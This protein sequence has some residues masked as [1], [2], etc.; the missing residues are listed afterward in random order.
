MLGL[1]YVIHFFLA[2]GKTPISY[3]KQG[4][5]KIFTYMF[6][7]YTAAIIGI[8]QKTRLPFFIV[9]GK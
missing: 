6:S 9:I 8:E 3:S 1:A 5:F 7:K 4:S 2:K